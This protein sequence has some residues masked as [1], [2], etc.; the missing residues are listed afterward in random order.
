MS[1]HTQ[2]DSYASTGIDLFVEEEHVSEHEEEDRVGSEPHTKSYYST[3]LIVERNLKLSDI[4]VEPMTQSRLRDMQTWLTAK[5]RDKRCLFGMIDPRAE[6]KESKRHGDVVTLVSYEHVMVV[7][8]R[9][10]ELI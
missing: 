3:S 1:R 7:A 4:E 5:C 6:L 10:K 2:A 8:E 9:A